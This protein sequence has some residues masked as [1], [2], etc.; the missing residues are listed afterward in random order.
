MLNK[1]I[2]DSLTQLVK[3]DGRTEDG[4]SLL[5]LA[6]SEVSTGTDLPATISLRQTLLTRVMEDGEI[7]MSLL[8]RLLVRH[9]DPMRREDHR[10][11]EHNNR[12]S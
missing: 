3:Q 6:C 8:H 11:W 7:L 2:M 12:P 10:V 4:W 9:Q 5:L 1:D